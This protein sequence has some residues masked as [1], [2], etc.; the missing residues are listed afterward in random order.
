L[1]TASDFSDMFGDTNTKRS[2]AIA[3]AP[4]FESPSKSVRAIVVGYPSAK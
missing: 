4:T 1:I 3:N 2:V